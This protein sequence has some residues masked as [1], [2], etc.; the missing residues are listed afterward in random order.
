[1]AIFLW[2]KNPLQN[3]LKFYLSI[4]YVEGKNLHEKKLGATVWFTSYTEK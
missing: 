2:T 3:F 1:M 4:F